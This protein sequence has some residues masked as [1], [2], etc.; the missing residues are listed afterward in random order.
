[1]QNAECRILI[2]EWF[3]LILKQYVFL[4]MKSSLLYFVISYT[5]VFR[6]S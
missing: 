4:I 2:E 1:M 3:K 5:F 6:I